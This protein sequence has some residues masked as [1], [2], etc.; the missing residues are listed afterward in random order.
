MLQLCVSI[1]YEATACHTVSEQR[2]S[3]KRYCS[4]TIKTLYLSIRVQAVCI[5]IKI[6]NRS[7]LTQ[8]SIKLR[9]PKV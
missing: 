7:H 9:N 4:E 2:G 8:K 6:K 1:N 3:D 5:A